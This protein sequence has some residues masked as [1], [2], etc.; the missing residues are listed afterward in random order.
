M[1][2]IKRYED[3]VYDLLVRFEDMRDD[4]NK[5]YVACIRYIRGLDYVRNTT[6][7][8]F[9]GEVNKDLPNIE[10]VF[11]GKTMKMP[12]GTDAMYALTASMT[13]Y[14]RDHK[15]V[16]SRIANSIRYAEKMPP[17]FSTVLMKD[18]M[19]ID[20]DYKEKLL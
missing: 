18:Y 16:M 6:L 12:T 13:T 4:V 19:Y 17:D 9:F 1:S 20:K 5:L 8:E 14:A 11:D 15:E 10:D 3:L 7:S 2:D